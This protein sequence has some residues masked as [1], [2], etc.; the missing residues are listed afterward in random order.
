MKKNK[1]NLS[2]HNYNHSAGKRIKFTLDQKEKN[3]GSGGNQN[4]HISKPK[5][6]EPSLTLDNH[7]NKNL[8]DKDY[9]KEFKEKNE[10]DKKEEDKLNENEELKKTAENDEEDEYFNQPL[11]KVHR[12]SMRKKELAKIRNNLKKKNVKKPENLDISTIDRIKAQHMAQNYFRTRLK[13]FNQIRMNSEANDKNKSDYT[14][15]RPKRHFYNILSDNLEIKTDLSQDKNNIINNKNNINL[16]KI[17]KEKKEKN[18]INIYNRNNR[19][20]RQTFQRLPTDIYRHINIREKYL[21]S[22]DTYK[23]KEEQNLKEDSKKIELEQIKER[24]KRRLNEEKKEQ[25]LKDQKEKEEKKLKEMEEK[26][27]IEEMKSK[28]P[29]PIKKKDYR[30]KFRLLNLDRINNLVNKSN[31]IN[32]INNSNYT[33]E[34]NKTSQS[35]NVL[36][37]QSTNVVVTKPNLYSRHI[38]GKGSDVGI[39]SIPLRK[40]LKTEAEEENEKVEEKENLSSYRRYLRKS[41]KIDNKEEPKLV[42]KAVIRVNKRKFENKKENEA[43]KIEKFEETKGEDKIKTEDN[44]R[45]RYRKKSKKEEEIT[46]IEKEVIKAIKIDIKNKEEANSSNKAAHTISTSF[47]RRRVIKKI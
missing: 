35:I 4:L 29:K 25:K 2:T 1:T 47:Y 26:K 20:L 23:E 21:G 32:S 3:S 28:I 18:N 30:K 42:Y 44:I 43:K 46:S 8:E 31:Y 38:G 34:T 24:E 40:I 33:E 10:K 36:T 39:P 16:N 7:N 27:K 22:K 15:T 19:L 11:M 45:I 6:R 5:V 37:S 17:S 41:H 12:M 14:I 9:L 13:Y